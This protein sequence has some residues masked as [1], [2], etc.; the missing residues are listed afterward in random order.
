MIISTNT[1]FFN[2]YKTL[3]KLCSE[4]YGG[5]NGISGYI[6]EME[7]AEWYKVKRIADWSDTIRKLKNFRYIRNQIAHGGIELDGNLCDFEDIDWI[8]EFYQRIING[9][10]PLSLLRKQSTSSGNKH[11]N[12]QNK[13]SDE[14]KYQVGSPSSMK[15][16]IKQTFGD[17]D[18]DNRSSAADN[19]PE[20]K[21]DTFRKYEITDDYS[22]PERR[23]ETVYTSTHSENKQIVNNTASRDS[24]K[25]YK[26]EKRKTRVLAGIIVV[27]AIIIILLCLLNL[28]LAF[29]LYKWRK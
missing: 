14:R 11:N 2:E 12:S 3:D 22:Q 1:E 10:D 7:S 27:A 29:E 25:E 19:S 15:D 23:K 6:D 5:S 9:T 28:G 4:I 13:V 16:L 20:I 8:K 18:F 21:S 17:T 24:K 26:S